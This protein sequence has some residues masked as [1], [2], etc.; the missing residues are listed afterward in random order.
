MQSDE[1]TLSVVELLSCEC[2]FGLMENS[3]IC[4]HKDDDVLSK[5]A[6]KF[7][8]YEQKQ[9]KPSFLFLNLEAWVDDPHFWELCLNFE[10]SIEPSLAIHVIYSQFHLE[11]DCSKLI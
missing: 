7:I 2:R 10:V 4:N 1:E 11:N 8:T 9:S 6:H 3:K 5:I